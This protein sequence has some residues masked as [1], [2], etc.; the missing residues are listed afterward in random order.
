MP[1][2]IHNSYS[3]SE[4]TSEP[5][6]GRLAKKAGGIVLAATAAIGLLAGGFAAGKSE[7]S[8]HPVAAEASKPAPAPQMPESLPKNE[9]EKYATSSERNDKITSM[10]NNISQRVLADANKHKDDL[11]RIRFNEH[12]PGAGTGLLVDTIKVGEATYVLKINAEKDTATGL[13]KVPAE[14]KGANLSESL[15]SAVQPGQFDRKEATFAEEPPISG[16]GWAV[17]IGEGTVPAPDEM[18]IG[19][20]GGFETSGPSAAQVGGMPLTE[21]QRIDQEALRRSIDFLDKAGI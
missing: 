3:Q 8:G 15:P 19:T 17:G 14:A 5:K 21:L 10:Y 9:S 1:E 2:Q 20:G 11:A 12:T 4:T 7:V 16:P 13:F 6:K 18:S